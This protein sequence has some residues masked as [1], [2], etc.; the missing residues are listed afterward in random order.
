MKNLIIISAFF[1]VCCKS[2]NR[3]SIYNYDAKTNEHLITPNNLSLFFEKD[4][5]DVIIF[6]VN[7][8]VILNEFDNIK[9]SIHLKGI[10]N[11]TI[12]KLGIFYFA[13]VNE[14]DTIYADYELHYWRYKNKSGF[15]KSKILEEKIASLKQ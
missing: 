10:S 11:E 13:F 7:D 3:I 12:N 9:E 8:K 6:D 1:L 2:T 14:A 15:Y 4:N 5:K